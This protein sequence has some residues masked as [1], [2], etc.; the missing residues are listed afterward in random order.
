M[1]SCRFA[2]VSVC[3][4]MKDSMDIMWGACS[5]I[6]QKHT[7][8][9]A[10]ND[11]GCP[12]FN[13]CSDGPGVMCQQYNLVWGQVKFSLTGTPCH[14]KPIFP[15]RVC[16]CCIYIFR[17]WLHCCPWSCPTTTTP[18]PNFRYVPHMHTSKALWQKFIQAEIQVWCIHSLSSMAQASTLLTMAYVDSS[19]GS[20]KWLQL[21]KDG[22]KMHQQLHTTLWH[23]YL[24]NPSCGV[25]C[26]KACCNCMYDTS[27]S[28]TEAT[29]F[30]PLPVQF[31]TILHGQKGC[32][33]FSG[34]LNLRTAPETGLPLQGKKS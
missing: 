16:L 6:L 25:Y 26:T 2:W 34:H 20:V 21:N 28:A 19:T 14:C 31:K 32:V 8:L 29:C 17:N 18:P 27:H 12:W 30:N 1:S 3:W 11:N 7:V 24:Y 10:V 5:P 4:S 22:C 9:P 13:P 23:I 15:C 33:F